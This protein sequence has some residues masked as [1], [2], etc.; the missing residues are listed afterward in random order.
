MTGNFICAIRGPVMLILLGI[1]MAIDQ[2]GSYSFGRTWPALLIV[3]GIFKLA[4]R[5]GRPAA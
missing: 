1:L 5:S 4:E 3:F 2:M